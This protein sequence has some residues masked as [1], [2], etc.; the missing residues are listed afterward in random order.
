M[1]ETSKKKIYLINK[2]SLAEIT[3]DKE[4][5]I[6]TTLN[7]DVE[8]YLI[9]SSLNYLNI[10]Q[11]I[12]LKTKKISFKDNLKVLELAKKLDIIINDNGTKFY[13]NYYKLLSGIRVIEHDIDRV[14]HLV[15]TNIKNKVN[16]YVNSNNNINQ[17]DRIFLI[18]KELKKRYK[19]INFIKQR[20]KKITNHFNPLPIPED[21]NLNK[22]Q[23]LFFSLKNKQQS[24]FAHK[25]KKNVLFYLTDKEDENILKKNLNECNFYNYE[26]FIEYSKKNV[27]MDK[28]KFKKMKL[29]LEENQVQFSYIYCKYFKN[30]F[31]ELYSFFN[32]NKK[33]IEQFLKQKKIDIFITA[34]STLISNSI[35]IICSQKKIPTL[36]L[37]HGG[38]FGHFSNVV[39][40]PQFTACNTLLDSNF[41][42]FQ[43]NTEKMKK[44]IIKKNPIMNKKKFKNQLIVFAS[45]K[46]NKINFNKKINDLNNKINIG[47]ICRTKSNV[48]SKSYT[49]FQSFFNFFKIRNDILQKIKSDKNIHINVSVYENEQI[50]DFADINLIKQLKINNRINF[51]IFRGKKVIEDSDIIIFEQFSTLLIEALFSKKPLIY[52]NNPY[53]HIFKDQIKMLKKQIYFAKNNNDMKKIISS[54]VFNKKN[55]FLFKKEI[56]DS[57]IKNFYK[58][59]SLISIDNIVSKILKINKTIL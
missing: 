12:K 39:P 3:I 25:N 20:T 35:K 48:A 33:N 45:T 34:H 5:T 42:F 15:K 31:N 56:A 14:S 8:K 24:F 32:V 50:D 43:V 18:L 26:Y 16:Y 47:Y 29:V 28:T 46:F 7:R 19:N 54:I 52:I 37:M 59:N 40:Y 9:N 57:F 38:N 30:I 44:I 23:K 17:E 58:N 11:S 13:S 10:D 51:N 22:K 21:L 6:Y 36:T 4:D 41:N 55:S 49:K 53:L 27:K 1:T 2:D